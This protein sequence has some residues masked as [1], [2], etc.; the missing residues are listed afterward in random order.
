MIHD[1][2]RKEDEYMYSERSVC[3][4]LPSSSWSCAGVSKKETS[5]QQRISKTQRHQKRLLTSINLLE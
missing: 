3:V 4:W 5:T 2:Q 1:P